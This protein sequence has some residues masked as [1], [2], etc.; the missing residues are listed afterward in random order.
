MEGSKPHFQTV[1]D[2]DENESQFEPFGV[3]VIA[4]CGK[5]EEVEGMEIRIAHSQLQD[6]STEESESDPDGTDQQIFPHR[7]EGTLGSMETD[8]RS[9]GKRGCFDSDP[10]ETEIGCECGECHHGDECAEDHGEDMIFHSIF[11]MF[12]CGGEPEKSVK[13]GAEE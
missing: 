1:T 10:E 9:T 12:S 13:C 6:E 8:Q 4:G 11:F 5:N 2:K 7:F 3:E